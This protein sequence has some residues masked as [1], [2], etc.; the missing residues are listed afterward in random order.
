MPLG[1][2]ERGFTYVA[3]LVAMLLLALS[4][5]GVMGYV[6]QQ[7]QRER[8]AELLRVGQSFAD[9]IAS[10]YQSSP[11]SVKTFPRALAELTSDPRWVTVKRHLREVYEDPITRTEMWGLVLTAEGTISGVY[12]MSEAAPIRSAPI[13][14]DNTR[15]PA[16]RHYS[17]WRFVFDP[18]QATAR[19]RP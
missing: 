1:S 13:F 3:L 17:E 5:N 18:S 2:R 14:L 10:Y 19:R 4:V 11:G 6:S 12:S 16:A 8:E 9:A 7:A 15:L